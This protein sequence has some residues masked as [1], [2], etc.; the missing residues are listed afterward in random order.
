MLPFAR[1]ETWEVSA[2]PAIRVEMECLVVCSEHS[3]GRDGS[4][5][6]GEPRDLLDARFLNKPLKCSCYKVAECYKGERQVLEGKLVSL[7]MEVQRWCD[8]C[9]E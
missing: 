1:E 9:P 3:L 6:L 2:T 8:H 4:E 5:V 7:V